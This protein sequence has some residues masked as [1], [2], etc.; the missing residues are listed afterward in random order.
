M[1]GHR[2]GAF[3][4]WMSRSIS[5]FVLSVGLLVFGMGSAQAQEDLRIPFPFLMSCG[6]TPQ[7]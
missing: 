2:G 1:D 6:R 4:L 3:G 5:V 7:R